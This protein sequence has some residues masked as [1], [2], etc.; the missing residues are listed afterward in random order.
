MGSSWA[1]HGLSDPAA[2][3]A[4]AFPGGTPGRFT[5]APGRVN[6]IGEH[7]DYNGLPVLP[8]A[9]RQ[10]VRI[11][12][13]PR[14]DDRVRVANTQG[15]F[16][17]REFTISGEIPPDPP[18][19]WANY[20]KAPCQALGQKFGSLA[21]FDALV[22]ST[23]PVAAGLSSSSAL[24]IAMGRTLLA[25]NDLQLPTLE[26]AEQMAQAERYTGTQGGGMDQAI[27]AGAVHG[28]ASRIEFHPLRMFQTP[29]PP[30]WRFVVAHTT[31][32]AEKSG[33]AQEA[34]NRR[35]QECREALAIVNKAVVANEWA[36][37]EPLTYPH[38][39]EQFCIQDLVE[40]GEKY[41]EGALL[42]RFRHVVTEGSR[43]YDAE[44]ALKRGDRFTFGLLMNSS[45]QSLREDYEVS[46]RE[47]DTLVGIAT[48]A[49]AEGARLTGAGFGGCIVALAGPDQVDTVLEQLEIRYYESR[50]VKGSLDEVLFVAEPAQGAT[51]ET[52]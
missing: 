22:S 36:R 41:L 5:R 12:F 45:H 30:D 46:S 43:V 20:L 31:V 26:F 38:L 11:L 52:F 48:D 15:E 17:L 1:D 18:G 40:L 49:G 28:H 8:M 51:V 23:L 9:L 47:L 19:D 29:V 14:D 27:S 39:L 32:R 50:K 35:T 7:T 2:A 16:G 42:K 34:Y 37:G 4:T 3:F 21:G 44:H 24:V 13:S 33:M 25:V 10:E 6:L